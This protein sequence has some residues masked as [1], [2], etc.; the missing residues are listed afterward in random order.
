M[1]CRACR[2]KDVMRL[3]CSMWSCGACGVVFSEYEYDERVYAEPGKIAD[4]AERAGSDVGRRLAAWRVGL[5]ALHVP[6]GSRVLDFGG[7]TC[8]FL[9]AAVVSGF[10]AWAYEPAPAMRAIA[11]RNVG[12]LA[13]QIL[14]RIPEE[15]FDAVTLWDVIEH[16]PTGPNES[17]AFLAKLLRPGGVLLLSTPDVAA[18]GFGGLVNWK[19]CKPREHLWLYRLD[20]LERALKWAGFRVLHHGREESFLRPDGDRK[21]I[22]HVAARLRP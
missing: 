1:T 22:L 2:G 15:T 11:G 21:S 17:M 3:P 14:D 12:G 7:G 5:L 9:A 10:N 18:P 19:H 6:M 8:D 16:L 20:V 13:D 4:W